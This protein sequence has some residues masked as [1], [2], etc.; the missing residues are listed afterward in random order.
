MDRKL[1]ALAAVFGRV[2]STSFGGGQMASI[3]REVVR[4]RGWLT[5]SE[6][7]ELLSV[8]QIA[9]GANPVNMAVLVGARVGGPVGAA[10]AFAAQTLPGFVILLAIAALVLD[11]RMSIFRAALRGCAAA[12][13]GITLANAI[14]MALPY[15][16]RALEL[17]L[18]AASALAMTALHLSLEITLLVLVPVSLAVHAWKRS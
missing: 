2:S 5:E 13:V 17:A 7:L 11:P 6:F 1:V 9:P 3:R 18:I 14:E 16:T 15:R 4:R 12:A 10:V 8:A